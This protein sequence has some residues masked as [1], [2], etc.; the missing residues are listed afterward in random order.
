MMHQDIPFQAIY[1]QTT[2]QVKT[3]RMGLIRPYA[4]ASM[5]LPLPNLDIDDL[6]D[7][8][9]PLPFLLLRDF[10]SRRH[11]RETLWATL[12]EASWSPFLLRRCSFFF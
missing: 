2:L 3:V 12:E 9:G 1:L 4:V 10:N 6:E 11:L 8:L 5:Y 7:L